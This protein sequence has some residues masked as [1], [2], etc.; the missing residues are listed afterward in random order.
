MRFLLVPS[1]T[2]SVL[3]V[4]AFMHATNK[5]AC[6]SA[7]TGPMELTAGQKR[8]LEV[9][10]DRADTCGVPLTMATMDVVVEGTVQVAS[11]QEWLVTY[12]FAR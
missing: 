5:I 12:S 8:P 4:S 10:F 11:R 6:L 3:R 2:G 7:L 1:Q 9:V